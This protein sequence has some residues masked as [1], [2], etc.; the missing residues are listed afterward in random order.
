[1]VFELF[2]S[3]LAN[4]PILYSLETPEKQRFFCVFKGYKKG[5]LA[6][7]GLKKITKVPFRYFPYE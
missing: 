4:V 5:T 1:M 3:F 2:N 7:Y 6:R